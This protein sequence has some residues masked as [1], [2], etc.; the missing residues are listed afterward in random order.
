MLIGLDASTKA[1]GYAFGGPAQTGPRSGVWPLPGADEHS[2][3]RS[4]KRGVQSLW[5]LGRM[6]KVEHVF[7]EAPFNNVGDGG[8]AHTAMVLTQIAGA[9]RGVALL[10]GATVTLK[11]VSTVRKH[12][13]GKGNLPAKVAKPL[14][15][16]RC[17]VLGWDCG[18]SFD[19]SDACAVWAL[20]M[21]LKYPS[22]QPQSTP[23]FAKGR[24]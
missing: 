23:L 21:A 24:E 6:L 19:R 15:F 13:I 16:E 11:A 12:F 14:V 5:E 9:L 17:R 4:I 2:L 3:D 1:I 20:G 8:S 7:I 10:M 18:D 22:W